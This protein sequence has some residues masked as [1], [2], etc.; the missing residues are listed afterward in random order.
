MSEDEGKA[1]VEEVFLNLKRTRENEF[2][3]NGIADMKAGRRMNMN[4]NI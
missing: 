2:W 1:S 3:A 4:E